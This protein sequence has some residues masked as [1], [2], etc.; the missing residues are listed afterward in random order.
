MLSA[1]EALNQYSTSMAKLLADIEEK[2][3]DMRQRDEYSL[4]YTFSEKME[5]N[6]LD[7]L[8][9]IMNTAGYITYYDSFNLSLVITIP[10][11]LSDNDLIPKP[12][13]S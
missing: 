6:K 13:N 5:N 10:V 8:S 7:H 4:V 2:I 9:R 12:Q 3:L 11:K 1:N